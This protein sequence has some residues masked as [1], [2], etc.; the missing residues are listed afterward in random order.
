M[1]VGPHGWTSSG[2]GGGGSATGVAARPARPG[3]PAFQ[4]PTNPESTLVASGWIEQQRRSKLRNSL[5]GHI[6]VACRRAETEKKKQL[7]GFSANVRM[8]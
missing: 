1:I 5:E 7:C 8:P 6:G 2:G 4:R 3:K